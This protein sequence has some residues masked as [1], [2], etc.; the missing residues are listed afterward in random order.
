MLT[1]VKTALVGTRRHAEIPL[2]AG[3]EVDALVGALQST[4]KEECLLLLAGAHALYEQAGKLAASDIPAIEPAP[5]TGVV[6]R[7]RK[8]IQLLTEVMQSPRHDLLL[9]FLAALKQSKLE[10]PHEV[11]PLALNMTDTQLRQQLLPVLGERGRWLSR[12]NP[13]WE[14]VEQGIEAISLQDYSALRR[15]WE[16]G[17]RAQRTL[18][19]SVIRRADP[20]E[21]RRWLEET[22]PQEKADTRAE[23][24]E[25]LQFGLHE[26]DE[27]LLERLLDDRSEQVRQIAASLLRQLP[28]SQL[29]RRMTERAQ[30]VLHFEAPR[31]VAR[32]PEDLPADWQRDGISAK[33]SAGRGKRAYWLEMIIG[34][35]PLEHWIAHFHQQPE[36]LLA[37]LEND[38][39]D[40]YAPDVVMGWTRAI[41]HFSEDNAARLSWAHA[42]WN[43]WLTRWQQEK[44]KDQEILSRL[45]V[46]LKMFPSTTAEKNILPFLVLG[47]LDLDA[48]TLLL[49]ML[50]RPWSDSFATQYLQL[51][52][53]VVKTGVIDQAYEWGK[54]LEIAA[55]ALPRATLQSAL[56]PWLVER[57]GQKS[58]TANALAQLVERFCEIVKLRQMFF[59]ELSA[60]K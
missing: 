47:R 33:V 37:A 2:D 10:L 41:E 57:P 26:D 12:F 20:M 17:K 44:K 52:R 48:L 23:L 13:R 58:W 49:E 18:A 53:Q 24:I 9:E 45:I 19:L 4:D 34:A 46:L 54:T 28:A 39:Y 51:A 56:S 32:P 42:L 59:E 15:A 7:S 5:A 1:L 21:G 22:L 38:P 16:E 6:L 31:L 11:L 43:Y 50:P 30:A 8:L 25:Q 29:V 35:A 27:P 40:P 36:K 60:T 55:R 14:W 3:H